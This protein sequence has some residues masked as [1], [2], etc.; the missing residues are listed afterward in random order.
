MNTAITARHPSLV[1]C[2]REGSPGQD[3]VSR[4]HSAGFDFGAPDREGHR[5]AEAIAPGEELEHLGGG[6]AEIAVT[7]RVFREGRRWIGDWLVRGP[8]RAVDHLRALVRPAQARTV[9]PRNM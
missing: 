9:C 2:L 7:G 4:W 5:V 8:A 1:G 3:E 6:G